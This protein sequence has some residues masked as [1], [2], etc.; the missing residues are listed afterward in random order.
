VVAW[1]LLEYAI[2]R[3]DARVKRFVGDFYEYTRN[4]GISRIGYFPA[5]VGTK[6]KL[7]G[8]D[9]WESRHPSASTA[10]AMEGCC[11][12]EMICIAIA[13]CDAGVGDYW[14]D[15]DQYVRNHFAEMQ[16]LRK[17]LMEEVSLAG[18]ESKIRPGTQI[19]DDVIE[20][21]V[22]AFVT[23]AEMTFVYPMWTMC[24]LGNMA[25]AHCKAWEAIMRYSDGVAQVNLP[26]NRASPWLDVD[27]YLP[28][29]GKVVLRNKTARRVHLRVPLWVGKGAVRCRV[30]G[31]DVAPIWLGNYVLIDG[32]CPGSRATVE[33]PMV[34]TVERHT[35]PTYAIEYTLRMKGNTLVGISPRAE[36][37]SFT[38]L[39]Q[40]D[41]LQI[42]VSK[43]YPIYD[44]EQY[45]QD[46][47]P[48]AEVTRFVPS[49]VS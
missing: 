22:G 31:K 1:G 23:C 2:A 28:Y 49:A 47:A 6:E 21:Q 20:R 10:I 46:T 30:D 35:E 3:N 45:R 36:T 11:L 33:F 9:S 17:D 38:R 18:P 16:L 34:E 26:L 4:L 14:D 5:V 42:Q 43:A 24:C 48:M 40:D 44:R 27:S 7:L 19:T 25:V 12:A 13:L 37:P 41:G 29:E 39:T 32:L 8:P 15:V